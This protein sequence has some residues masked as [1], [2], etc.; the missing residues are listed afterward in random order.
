MQIHMYIPL[1]IFIIIFL[2]T[3]KK[4]KGAENLLV[5]VSA[6]GIVIFVAL[7]I[8]ATTNP[9]LYLKIPETSVE[10][11]DTLDI[12]TDGTMF[13]EETS[14]IG[15]SDEYIFDDST[16]VSDLDAFVKYEDTNLTLVVKKGSDY[17]YSK[18]Y[19]SASE[20]DFKDMLDIYKSWK[21]N[22]VV[23]NDKSTYKFLCFYFEV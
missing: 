19:P 22:G 13:L 7:P 6:I 4:V 16:N 20:H 8:L 15:Y 17:L 14:G 1:A 18:Y 9:E 3:Y 11:G 12:G 23:P 2:V 10:Y 21:S 5:I